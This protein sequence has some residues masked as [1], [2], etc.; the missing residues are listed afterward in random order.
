MELRHL[1]SFVAIVEEK[2]FSAAARKL[3]LAQ[4]A[5]SRQI[6]DLEEDLGIAVL[7]RTKREVR[8]TPAGHVLYEQ[9]KRLLQQTADTA[10]SA[11]RAARGEAGRLAVG[12]FGNATAPFLP[13]L[14]TEFHRKFPAVRV[15]LC[16]MNPAAQL[17]AF[18]QGRIDFG[19]NR[20]LPAADRAYLA[21][22]LVYRDQLMAALPQAHPLA[23]KKVVPLAALAGDPF[24]LLAR[25]QAPQLVDQMTVI[26]NQAGFSP[27]VRIESRLM[28][29]VLIFV[30]C[31]MGVSLVPACVGHLRQCGVVLRPIT[32]KSPEIDLVAV[33]NKRVPSPT[34]AAFL[35]VVRANR[36]RI[37]RTMRPA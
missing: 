32:P 16:E 28:S 26:C 1:R 7:W 13:S 18:A 8:P 14:I 24:V 10:L 33:W 23:G 19:F 36:D 17:E 25:D 34:A 20:P 11:Q 3:H 37:R 30:A 22:E 6:K 4:P 15:D 12:F 27:E 9:A 31:A 5:L 29:T 21:E 35:S 2:G